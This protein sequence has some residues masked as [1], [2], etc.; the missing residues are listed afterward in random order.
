MFVNC[1]WMN[2]GETSSANKMFSNRFT[3]HD[4]VGGRDKL[5]VLNNSLILLQNRTYLYY[6]LHSY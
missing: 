3:I 2:D 6:T 4:A 5:F 1:L